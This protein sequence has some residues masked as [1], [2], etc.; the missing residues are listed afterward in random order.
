MEHELNYRD[1]DDNC[2]ACGSYE[3][4]LSKTETDMSDELVCEFMSCKACG[5]N[6]ELMYDVQLWQIRYETQDS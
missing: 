3:I 4:Y 6:F 5:Q 1:W 2:P